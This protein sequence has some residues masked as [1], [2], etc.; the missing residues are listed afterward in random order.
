M[1]KIYKN[2]HDVEYKESDVFLHFTGNIFGIGCSAFD[3]K[4]ID[5]IVELKHRDAN[6]GFI[7]LFSSLEQAKEYGLP[8]LENL[9]IKVL[10]EEFYPGNLTAILQTEDRRFEKVWLNSKIG[11]RIPTSKILRDLIDKVGNP[12]VSTSINVSGNPFCTDLG[13]LQHEF[14]DWFNWGLYN[15]TEPAD[16]PLPST[17]IDFVDG[18]KIEVKC[19]REG[20][21]P[22]EQVLKKFNP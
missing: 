4:A 3:S 9:R 13:V 19:L 8:Q 20:S 7:V 12:I 15:E 18:E 2:P 6:K 22:F 17:V 10:L 5:R 14:S 1:I 21:I 16:Q 11:I